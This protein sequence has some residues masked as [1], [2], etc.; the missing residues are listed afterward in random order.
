MPARLQLGALV[1]T[2]WLGT[3]IMEAINVLFIE[4]REHQLLFLTRGVA[5]SARVADPLRGGG[6]VGSGDARGSSSSSTVQSDRR[7]NQR[8]DQHLL[9]AG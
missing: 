1:F 6:S 8:R 5:G 4:Q 9:T 2:H 3:G 7:V